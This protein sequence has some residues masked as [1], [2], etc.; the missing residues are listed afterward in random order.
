[1]S[2]CDEILARSRRAGADECEAILSTKRTITVRVTDSE[3]AEIKENEEQ[4]AGVRL[5]LGK[6]IAACQS[7]GL[8]AAS[9]V[10]DAVSASR[11]LAERKFWKSLPGAAPYRAIDGLNDQNLWNLDA[12]GASDI[13][14]EMINSAAHPRVASISGSLNIVCEEFQITNTSGLNVSDRATYIAGTINS[15]SEGAAP[16]SGIGQASSRTLSQFD[17]SSAGR[18]ASQM[19]A[20]S[21]GASAMEPS[22]LS[23]IFEP[24][25]VGEL[26]TFVFAP[27][28]FLKTYSEGRSCF[29]EKVGARIAPEA[30]S[31]ADRPH[32]SNGLGSKPFDDEGVPTRDAFYVRGGVFEGTY[33]DSYNAFKEDAETSG[34]A[35]RPGSPLGRSSE[36]IP[37]AAPHN[38]TICPGDAKR[39][40]IIRDTKDGIIVSRLWY[41]YAV[42]PIRGDF[43]CT[44]RSGIW[45]VKDGAVTGPA[46][47]VRII[48]SLPALLQGISAIGDNQRTVLPWAAGPVTSPTIRCDGVSVSTI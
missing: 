34:N 24:M 12:A 37:V 36:P 10:D 30:F 26:L 25:A 23:V 43:S 3:I 15:D 40:E 28:F 33:S 41:A 42:N 14:L 1:M 8:D 35:S 9:M 22:T 7:T 39:D 16:A 47:Q 17:P 46:R 6:R 29:S 13:A 27:N 21:E 18:D 4:S 32:A 45:R 11:S 44:A 38:L 2:V 19:C 48:H 31:L 20:D 5:I